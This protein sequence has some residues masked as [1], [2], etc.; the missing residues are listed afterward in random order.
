[1]TDYNDLTPSQKSIARKF[2]FTAE[3]AKILDLTIEEVLA[4]NGLI[5]HRAHDNLTSDL[6]AVNN[7]LSPHREAAIEFVKKLESP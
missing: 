6:N 5:T 3:E 2:N 7:A 1:M 4:E